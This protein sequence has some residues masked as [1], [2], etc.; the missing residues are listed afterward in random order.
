MSTRRNSHRTTALGVRP[1]RSMEPPR[2]APQ[3]QLPPGSSCRGRPPT[4]SS[5]RSWTR[6][7][8]A[9]ASPTSRRCQPCCAPPAAARTLRRA[10]GPTPRPPPAP[11]HGDRR[12]HGLPQDLQGPKRTVLTHGPLPEPILPQPGRRN[13]LEADDPLRDMSARADRSGVRLNA[14]AHPRRKPHAPHRGAVAHPARSAACRTS[15]ERSDAT[16]TLGGAA[17]G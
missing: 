1:R 5:R 9:F 15:G 2:R 8:P 17:A 7:F 4:R 6:S 12:A 3:R 10:A 14:S 16:E 13:P 11:D